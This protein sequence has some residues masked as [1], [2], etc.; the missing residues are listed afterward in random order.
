MSTDQT[1]SR[2][3]IR[4]RGRVLGPYSV[5]QLHALRNRGQFSRAH[6]ISSDRQTWRRAADIES[7]FGAA[8]PA[9]PPE[10]P[11]EM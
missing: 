1:E 2:Y 9:A 5:P 7:L 3:Y 10:E 11:P 6:E 8:Q 4:I